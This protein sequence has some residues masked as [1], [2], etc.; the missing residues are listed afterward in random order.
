MSHVEIYTTPFCPFCYRAKMLLGKKGIAFSEINVMMRPEKRREM[1]ARADG[2]STVPQI[3]VDGEHV[4][5]CDDLT[6]LEGAGG[7]DARLGLGD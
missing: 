6:R 5:D 3:F 7:L 2:Q 4:G 1:A